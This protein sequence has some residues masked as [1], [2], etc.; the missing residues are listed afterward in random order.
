MT[1]RGR[2]YRTAALA[3]GSGWRACLREI[4][5]RSA[6][7]I[8]R[9]ALPSILAH[10]VAAVPHYRDL[11]ISDVRLEAF[12][13]LSR[14]TLRTEYARLRS[15]DVDPRSCCRA[16]TGGS[17]GEP[18]WVL[19]DR[20][21]VQWDYATEMAYLESFCGM[22]HRE[23][24]SARRIAVWHRRRL[25]PSVG[26]LKR[27]VADLLGQVAYIEPYESLDDE[28]LTVFLRRINRH[29]P[30]MI[31]AFAATLYELARHALDAGIALHRPRFIVT[32]IEMLFPAMRDVIERAFGCP[33]HNM[34]GAAEVGR[35]AAECAHGRLHVLAHSNHVEILR[36]DGRV[37]APGE[38]GR[39]V[40]TSLHN[41]AMPLIRYDIGDLGTLS[42]EACPCGSPL[43][44]LEA[45]RG[46]I[47]EHFV[48]PDGRLVFGGRF[49]AMFYGHDWIREFQ[50]LQETVDR[51]HIRFRCTP[52]REIPDEAIDSLTRVV[53]GQLGADCQVLWEEVDHIP[54]SPVGKHLHARSLVWEE[55][56]D[57]A[58]L[59]R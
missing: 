53:Q 12:P 1:I 50:V 38:A 40:I 34:Y 41:R 16:S 33:V 19:Q 18:V 48:R 14:E 7:E 28:R 54:R 22:D 11:G 32:S 36:E 25:R 23:Y 31:L 29:R 26:L 58:R 44:V 30:A 8:E 35:I 10:A 52:K 51:V 45:L 39:I 47:N 13:L 59:G 4:Q 3:V 6:V 2:L 57:P 9:D 37:A 46:R 43:P 42:N 27:L 55:I 15:E 56:G 20:A 49:I 21:F 24:L 17:T 5:S